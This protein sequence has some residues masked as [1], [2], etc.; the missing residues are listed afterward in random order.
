MNLVNH[1]LNHLT[2]NA[3]MAKDEAL[4][5][6][7]KLICVKALFIVPKQC[8]T[9][10]SLAQAFKQIVTKWPNNKW[11]HI[12]IYLQNNRDNISVQD[13]YYYYYY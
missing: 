4:T 10:R 6:S 8:L 9:S 3:I 7:A 1:L 11:Y 5:D 13:I 12:F 2:Y